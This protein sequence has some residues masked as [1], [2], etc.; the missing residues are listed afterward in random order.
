MRWDSTIR[1][2]DV[3]SQ[4]PIGEPLTGHGSSVYSVA[5]SPDGKTLASGSLDD[6]IRLW[7]VASQRPLGQPFIGHT[8]TVYS[9]AFSPDGKLLAS[10]SDDKTVRLIDIPDLSQQQASGCAKINRNLAP[11]EWND[12]VSNSETY[13]ATCPG[14]PLFT[15]QP[16]STPTTITPTPLPTSN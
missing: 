2:W 4:K 16:T 7:D 10:G 5:F 13:R 11:A 15:P 1:L 6:T 3:A 8:S 12:Y 9:V 14:L